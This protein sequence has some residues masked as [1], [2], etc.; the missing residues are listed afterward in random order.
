MKVECIGGPSSESDQEEEPTLS[1]QLREE[2]E[3]ILQRQWTL[4]FCAIFAVLILRTPLVTSFVLLIAVFFALAYS[5]LNPLLS[6]E[7]IT[8]AL[9]RYSPN[10]SGTRLCFTACRFHGG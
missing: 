9:L 5:D 7:Q 8:N 6:S 4:P 1:G 10:A 2:R 3:G